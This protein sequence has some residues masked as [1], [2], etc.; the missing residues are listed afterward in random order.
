MEALTTAQ[1]VGVEGANSTLN[2]SNR[3]ALAQQIQGIQQDILGLANTSYNGEYLFSGTKT[4]TQPY[5]ADPNS[6]T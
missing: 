2:T 1:S 4:T 5:V 6:N 3:Q